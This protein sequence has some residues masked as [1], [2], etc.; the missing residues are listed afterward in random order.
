[1]YCLPVQR[2][3]DSS[4]WLLKFVTLAVAKADF[5]ITASVTIFQR[6]EAR[7]PLNEDFTCYFWP[8]RPAVVARDIAG[9]T[10]QQHIM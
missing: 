8:K 5:F 6:F 1:M 7:K 10:A 2:F 3:R 9:S 4:E